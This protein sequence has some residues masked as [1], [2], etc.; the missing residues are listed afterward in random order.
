MLHELISLYVVATD[1]PIGQAGDPARGLAPF[2]EGYVADILPEAT[3]R[4]F[5][6][7]AA[8]VMGGFIR[9]VR[10][11]WYPIAQA[12]RG[13]KTVVGGGCTEIVPDSAG[14]N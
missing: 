2:A 13:L 11:R 9:T 3:Q 12:A 5:C 10:A 1:C 14:S 4:L 7:M 6:S 8:C